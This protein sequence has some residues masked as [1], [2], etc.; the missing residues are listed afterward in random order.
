M[1]IE[2]SLPALVALLAFVMWQYNRVRARRR[3]RGIEAGK[4]CLSCDRAEVLQVGDGVHCQRCGFVGSLKGI[5]AVPV[6]AG[7]IDRLLE[8]TDR[9]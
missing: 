8:P 5:T 9:A 2:V 3:L 1:I 4:R 7:D 6:N